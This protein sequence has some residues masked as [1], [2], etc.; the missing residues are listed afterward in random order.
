MANSLLK[1]TVELVEEADIIFEVESQ[2]LNT[3][4]QHSDT[5]NSHTKR[6]SRID[7]RVDAVGL[8]DIRVNHSATHNLQPTGTL[9]YRATLATAEVARYI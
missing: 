1:Y 5:L 8:Q 2:I 7:F 9:T 4:L 6:K 3:K